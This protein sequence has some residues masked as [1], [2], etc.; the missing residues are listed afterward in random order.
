MEPK[1]EDQMTN[2]GKIIRKG[3]GF[4]VRLFAEGTGTRLILTYSR[5]PDTYA[6]SVPAG[7]HILL[8]QLD[9]VLQGSKEHYPFGGEETAAGNAMKAIYKKML[10]QE[11][12]ELKT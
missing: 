10:A 12:P 11:Y 8:D 9:A 6:N 2:L 7:W 1:S 4:E 5:L 3:D